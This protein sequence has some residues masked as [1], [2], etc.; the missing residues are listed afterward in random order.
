MNTLRDAGVHTNDSLQEGRDG[1]GVGGR[2]E[3]GRDR[4]PVCMGCK[5]IPDSRGCIALA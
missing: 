5:Y 1:E 2:K 3:G 4:M